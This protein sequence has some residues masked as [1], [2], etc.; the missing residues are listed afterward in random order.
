MLIMP[1][2]RPIEK[3]DTGYRVRLDTGTGY[4]AGYLTQNSNVELNL[5]I[6]I[7]GTVTKCNESCSFSKL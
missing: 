6:L 5:K 3:P 1:N 4:P 7:T 2:I